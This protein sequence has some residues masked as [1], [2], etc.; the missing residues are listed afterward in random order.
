MPD[1]VV[2]CQPIRDVSSGAVDVDRDRLVTLAGELTKPLD[3]LAGRVLLDVADQIDVTEPADCSFLT[4]SLTASTIS[5]SKRS[6]NSLIF[7]L[8]A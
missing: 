6:F 7:H 4:N 8:F 3:S 1:C 5:L 2:K